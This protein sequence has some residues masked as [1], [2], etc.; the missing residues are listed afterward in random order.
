M[1]RRKIR[2]RDGRWLVGGWGLLLA[3]CVTSP[4]GRQQLMLVD[5]NTM[6]QMGVQAFTEIKGKTPVVT[7]P[8]INDYVLCVARPITAMASGQTQVSSWEIRVFESPEANAFALPGGKIGVFTGLLKVAKTPGQLAAVLGHET[9]HVI[10]RHSAERV[11]MQQ[12]E[13]GALNAA[14]AFISGGAQPTATHQLLMAALGVGLQVGVALPYSRTQESEADLIGE[15]LMA[16]AGFDPRES[17]DLWQNMSAQGGARPPAWLSTH[18]AEQARIDALR[19][20]LPQSEAL[21]QAARK[22]GRV[23][24]CRP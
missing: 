18:P 4:L 22:A 16:Q 2:L 17:I 13:G 6:A 14:S 3:A 11:S 1:M 9:G 19:R 23:P 21:Y 24:G 5:D 12:L 10:A 8:A 15:D 20:R 7:N